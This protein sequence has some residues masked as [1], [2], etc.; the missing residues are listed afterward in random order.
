M[1]PAVN[2]AKKYLLKCERESGLKGHTV[3]LKADNDVYEVYH[4]SFALAAAFMKHS[5]S[6]D[7]QQRENPPLSK[8]FNLLSKTVDE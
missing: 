7:K 5:F 3:T 2:Q 1:I 6:E 4:T 8:V